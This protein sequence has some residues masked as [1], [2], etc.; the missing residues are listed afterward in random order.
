MEAGTCVVARRDVPGKEGKAQ[1]VPLAGEA[2]AA[3]IAGLL[4]EV[5]ANLLAQA[6]A[7]AGPSLC[8]GSSAFAS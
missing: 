2:C 4:E 5:Q 3:H 6:S 7:G 8:V 1:G